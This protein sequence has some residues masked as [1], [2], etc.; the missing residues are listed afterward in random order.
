MENPFTPNTQKALRA[1][2]ELIRQWSTGE[3]TPP[4]DPGEARTIVMTIQKF[5]DCLQEVDPSLVVPNDYE[6]R[7]DVQHVEIIWRR[8]DWFSVLLPEPNATARPEP[9]QTKPVAI[10]LLYVPDDPSSVELAPNDPATK[11]VELTQA[12]FEVFLDP[13]MAGYCCTQCH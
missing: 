2:G 1:F 13:Y 11:K 5:Q 8:D 12:N 10:P 4:G 6:I 7:N 9:G 3:K